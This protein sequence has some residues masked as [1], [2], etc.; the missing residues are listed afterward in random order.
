MPQEHPSRRG[1]GPSSTVHGVLGIISILCIFGIVFLYARGK[2]AAQHGDRLTYSLALALPF[3]V[4]AAVTIAWV[5]LWL[6][7]PRKRE[8]F[9]G[10]TPVVRLLSLLLLGGGVV[11]GIFIFFLATCGGVSY[12][13]SR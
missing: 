1:R 7:L 6:F 13:M 8:V 2:E 4:L 9:D 11:V 3:G 12:L 10:M 5:F